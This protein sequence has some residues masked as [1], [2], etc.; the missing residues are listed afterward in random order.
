MRMQY[1]SS[2]AF[3]GFPF[4]SGTDGA[5]PGVYSTEVSLPLGAPGVTWRMYPVQPGDVPFFLTK[6]AVVGFTD[7]IDLNVPG[8][9]T[10]NFAMEWNGYFLPSATDTW[11][12]RCISRW[13]HGF[14]VSMNAA[15]PSSSN[16][17]IFA[18][19]W[20]SG[21]QTGSMR[22]YSGI[23]VRMRIQFF[24]WTT[25]TNA[26][27]YFLEHTRARL[28][29]AV[30]AACVRAADAPRCERRAP[31]SPRPPGA[32][33]HPATAAT[34]SRPRIRRPAATAWCG[35]CMQGRPS[36]PSSRLRRRQRWSASARRWT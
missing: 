14:W 36:R 23:Y 24:A 16:A 13:G 17:L 10:I 5:T 12:F 30:C 1:S 2:S 21:Y 33:A 7:N 34:G 4:S 22:M 18:H 19:G 28:L 31:P 29:L 32:G 3:S 8:L 35:R 20:A 26:G 11:S 9:P 6:P 15:S 27:I 25:S